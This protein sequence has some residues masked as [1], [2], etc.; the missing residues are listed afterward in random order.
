[1]GKDF[2]EPP[3]VSAIKKYVY[4]T[5]KKT[6]SVKVGDKDIAIITGSASLSNALRLKSPEIKRRCQIEKRLTFRIK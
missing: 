3:E 6:V 4:D 5:F 1:M 2:D